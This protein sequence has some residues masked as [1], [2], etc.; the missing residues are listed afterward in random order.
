M[1]LSHDPSGWLCMCVPWTLGEKPTVSYS[2]T[3]VVTS[4]YLQ[5]LSFLVL[6]FHIKYLQYD[7]NYVF[8]IIWCFFQPET[9]EMIDVSPANIFLYLKKTSCSSLVIRDFSLETVSFL[10]PS[11]I[12]RTC[13]L[14]LGRV[15]DCQRYVAFVE[16]VNGEHRR[17]VGDE[18]TFTHCARLLWCREAWVP[19]PNIPSVPQRK[20]NPCLEY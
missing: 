19:Q 3:T 16:A 18:N 2:V 9:R 7:Q 10:V 17:F 6:L 5:Q 1:S 8:S 4:M 14:F 20:I 15:I 12:C 13:L 11:S